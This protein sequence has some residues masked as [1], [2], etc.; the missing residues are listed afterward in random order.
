[1]N[2][3]TVVDR[4]VVGKG[5][6]FSEKKLQRLNM[7]SPG[8]KSSN[9]KKKGTMTSQGG[10]SPDFRRRQ[11]NLQ[12][13]KNGRGGTSMTSGRSGFQGLATKKNV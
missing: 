7:S 8:G 9:Y 12:I 13:S 2:N 3:G 11:S 6:D 5:L 1:M 4:T 10:D